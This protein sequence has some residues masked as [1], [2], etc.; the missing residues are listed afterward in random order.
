MT[1]VRRL[2]QEVARSQRLASVGSLA[3]G[4]AHEIRNPLSSLKGF[5]TYF[6]DRHGADPE[7]GKIATIMIQETERLNRVIGQLLEFARPPQLDRKPTNLA[8]LVRQ[9]LTSSRSGP[10]LRR[11]PPDGTGRP[12][13]NP[14]GRRPAEAGPPNLFLNALAAMEGGGRCPS[15]SHTTGP[16]P[17]RR[18]GYGRGHQKR[19]WGAFSTLLHDQALG[20]GAGP[21]HRP[22]DRR[23]PRRRDPPRERARAGN[24]G[25]GE[26]AGRD[27]TPREDP[28][29]S[30]HREP[31]PKP[32]HAGNAHGAGNPH[33][34]VGAA[35]A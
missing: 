33:A 1:E 20:H 17:D 15:R 28:H 25:H 34:P 14:G 5:A 23:G 9:A 18:C 19:T 12:A 22:Q 3:A 29:R 11:R 7:D 16:C 2:E 35:M 27:L 26:P 13:G 8:A 4:V 6:R 31:D 10:R 32:R 30:V 21:R 24:D